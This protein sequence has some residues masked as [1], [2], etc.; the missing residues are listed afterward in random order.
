M[1]YSGRPKHSIDKNADD[2]LGK[3]HHM[4]V[5]FLHQ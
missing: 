2:N 4:E 3:Y 5:F 1:G